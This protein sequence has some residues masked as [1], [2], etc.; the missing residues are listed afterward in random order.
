MEEGMKRLE[1]LRGARSYE[2]LGRAEVSGPR[3]PASPQPLC[4]TLKRHL[5]YPKA[6]G[7]V[8]FMMQYA[9]LAQLA[10]LRVLSITMFF[11]DMKTK[12]THSGVG[13]WA[14][15]RERKLS[16]YEANVS[17]MDNRNP[18]IVWIKLRVKNY[19]EIRSGLPL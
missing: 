16:N 13:S 11:T 15:D 14:F 6:P 3:P 4:P 7:T 17:T 2:T 19:T 1:L 12:L 18:E 8:R 9:Q 5:T 10:Q